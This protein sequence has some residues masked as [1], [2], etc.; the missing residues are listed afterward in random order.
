[1]AKKKKKTQ[2]ATDVDLQ[3]PRRYLEGKHVVVFLALLGLAAGL[4]SWGYYVQLQKRPMEFWGPDNAKLLMQA[5]DVVALRLVPSD[6]MPAGKEA[7]AI[8]GFNGERQR[9]AVV[10]FRDISRAG[11]LGIV[12]QTLLNDNT[13]A[14]SEKDDECEPA[15]QYALQFADPLTRQ[16]AMLFLS[17]DCPRARLVEKS[18]SIRPSAKALRKFLEDQF[19]EQEKEGMKDGAK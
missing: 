8:Y 3:Q 7:I 11:G 18:V 13:Y 10:D 4:T 15:W 6:R 5:K 2:R 12:R 9:W 14:W 19:K 1:M 17:L 16:E